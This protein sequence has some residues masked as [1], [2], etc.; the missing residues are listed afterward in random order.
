M[1]E[2]A[3]ESR[4]LGS[5]RC[6]AA[7]AL[8]LSASSLC[9]AFHARP[10]R[11]TLSAMEESFTTCVAIGRRCTSGAL[12]PQIALMEMLIASE[13]TDTVERALTALEGAAEPARLAELTRVFHDNRAGCA[14]IAAILRAEQTPDGARSVAESLAFCRTLF[15]GLVSQSEETS[16]ALYS[17]GNPDI[18][19]QASAEI[20]A[21]LQRDALLTPG[22]RL[23]DVGCGIGR[24][25]SALA[26]RVARVDAIDLSPQMVAAASRRCAELGN[27]HV[28]LCSGMDF[29][30]F[31]AQSMD[32][33]LAVDSFPYVVQAG[34]ALMHA[35]FAEA[36]R[37]LVQGGQLVILNF[38]YRADLERDRADASALAG[39]HGFVPA[40]LGEQPFTLWNGSVFSLRRA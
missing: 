27:V 30:G 18:L 32:L 22:T 4:S 21:L 20:V 31:A 29:A 14:K 38:S 2:H 11:V 36:A 25:A 39:Q 26:P 37:V 12:S 33:V 9:A 23:L 10:V 24:M 7:E 28:R 35:I 16:V 5:C 15:D 40:V 1:L 6:A 17:L 8:E 19:A 3:N 13:D 34:E